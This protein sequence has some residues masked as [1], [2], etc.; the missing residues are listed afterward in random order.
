MNIN[1]KRRPNT[2]SSIKT[3]KQK[4]SKLFCSMQAMLPWLMWYRQQKERG[5]H[6]ED[7]MLR[8][9]CGDAS[10]CTPLDLKR[11]LNDDLHWE[12]HDVRRTTIADEFD[13]AILKTNCYGAKKYG[14]ACIVET[15]IPT[16]HKYLTCPAPML[17][18]SV[19]PI[20][21]SPPQLREHWYIFDGATRPSLRFDPNYKRKTQ[22]K[23]AKARLY[24]I[25]RKSTH[26][27]KQNPITDYIQ[28]AHKMVCDSEY[29]RTK[30]HLSVTR[31]CFVGKSSGTSTQPVVVNHVYIVRHVCGRVLVLGPTGFRYDHVI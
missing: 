14:H 23:I 27:L 11:L 29:G 10:Y 31:P 6:D 2:A 16:L 19:M 21:G 3:R 25:K 18:L 1:T 7:D 15:R 24:I 13:G 9:I 30:A 4:R 26:G 12:S 17:I 28:S 5:M 22:P 8:Q 20:P